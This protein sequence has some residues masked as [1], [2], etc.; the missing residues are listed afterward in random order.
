M[1][2]E[3]LVG[4]FQRF[5]GFLRLW[6]PC[7]ESERE[8]VKVIGRRSIF[9]WKQTSFASF[10]PELRECEKEKAKL[11]ILVPAYLR[12]KNLLLGCQ[13]LLGHHKRLTKWSACHSFALQQITF[14]A[15]EPNLKNVRPIWWNAEKL[16]SRLQNGITRTTESGKER[17]CD[18][19]FVMRQ[20]LLF[21]SNALL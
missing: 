13:L 4:Q 7:N 20:L 2:A 12:E 17:T 6:R 19:N 21:S 14:I 9:F 16:P 18:I 1:R 3:L 15:Y 10:Q 11:A 5:P 8:G